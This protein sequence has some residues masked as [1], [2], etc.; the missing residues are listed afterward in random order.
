MVCDRQPSCR[1]QYENV[2][3]VNQQDGL[4]SYR[5]HFD[6]GKL[7]GLDLGQLM[8]WISINELYL[9]MSIGGF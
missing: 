8:L 6:E 9:T 1:S 4:R 3:S 2:K 7:E 5:S